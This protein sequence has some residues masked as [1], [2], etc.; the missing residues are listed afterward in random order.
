MIESNLKFYSLGIVVVDKKDNESIITV[1]PI[2]QTTDVTGAFDIVNEFKSKTKDRRGVLSE[3]SVSG[4]NVLVADW[5]PYGSPN[6]SSSPD[7]VAGET[8]MIMTYADTNKYY[9]FT[10]N[11][12]NTLRGRERVVHMFSNLDAGPR[13]E[14]IQ[15][16]NSYWYMVDTKDK[17]V[18]LHTSDN[19]EEKCTYDIILNTGEGTITVKDNRNNSMVLDSVNGILTTL[20]TNKIVAETDYI[21]YVARVDVTGTVGENQRETIGEFLSV[22]CPKMDLGE[23]SDLEPSTLGDH[24]ADNLKELIRQINASQVIGN[25]G[26]PTS[27][28][29]AVTMVDVPDLLR[30]GNSYSVKNRNQ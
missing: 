11:N 28:I 6:R 13:E 9:W 5:R 24:L 4:S 8:V 3:V 16:T 15:G 1:V 12:E 7:V 14:P 17:I 19:D 18:H 23:P 10:L 2:E 26:A 27:A 22:D 21:E 25:L 30:N 20:T 29:G